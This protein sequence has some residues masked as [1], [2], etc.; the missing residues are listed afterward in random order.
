MRT[1]KIY[2][3]TNEINNKVYIGKTNDFNKRK[4]EHT[5]YDINDNSIFHRALK[6]YGLNNFK[7]EIID[8]A[9][10]LEEINEKEKY[11][12]KKYNTFK[13]N[14]YNMTKGGDGGSMW[15]ARPVVVLDKN[16]NFINR[17]DS[18]GEAE[19]K[20]GFTNTSV[21]TCCKEKNRTHKGFLFMFEDEYIKNGAY[22]YEKLTNKCEKKVIQYSKEGV[23]IKE[24]N[25]IKEASEQTNT[26]R[27]S[28]ILVCKG[29]YKT[30]NGYIWSYGG[31]EIDKNEHIKKK[32]GTEIL[33]L[34]K[35]T[36]EVIK[37][38]ESVA[39]AG[40]KL[41]VKYKCIHKV[42]DKP[43]RTAY[44]FKWVTKKLYTNTEVK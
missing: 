29:N 12:I 38:Y 2:K 34:D 30:A 28:I 25:S 16:G 27:T 44:G 43:N 35:V 5:L 40:R 19:K 17:Y 24:F 10:T 6:K 39:E 11:Y 13:P 14:G 36:N 21:L 22:E 37:E 8:Y 23:K 18:A 9:K 32:K 42:L 33:Q 31:V 20:G 1:Y 4:K 15:N 3:V 7:W 41:N 26:R